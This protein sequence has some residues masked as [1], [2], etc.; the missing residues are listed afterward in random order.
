MKSQQRSPVTPRETR[1]LKLNTNAQRGE[2]STE[3]DQKI[4]FAKPQAPGSLHRINTPSSPHCNC[5]GRLQVC[6]IC[7]SRKPHNAPRAGTPG[8]RPP[9][10]LLRCPIQSTGTHFFGL[11]DKCDIQYI[12][13]VNVSYW[14]YPI[15]F[16][17]LICGLLV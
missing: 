4:I 1:I 11:F 15:F 5:I 8:F 7:L 9:E 14:L 10:V 17:R 2:K 13:L 6:S 12:V 3:K 16:Q